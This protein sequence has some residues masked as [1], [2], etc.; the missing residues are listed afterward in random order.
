LPIS[1]LFGKKKVTSKG[2]LMKI[3]LFKILSAFFCLS[4]LSLYAD[5]VRDSSTGVAFPSEITIEHA[6]KQYL[7]QATGVAT[8]KKFFVKVYSVASYLQDA[9]QNNGDKFSAIMNMDKAKQ[10][11]L[12]FVHDAPADKVQ[13]GYQDSFHKVLS[14]AQYNQMQSQ[15]NTFVQFF[16][17]DMQKGGEQVIRWFPDGY[18][19]VLING[20]K[21][22]S[23][24]NSELAKAIWNIWFGSNS[25]VDRDQLVSLMH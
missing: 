10:L 12:K 15:I 3:S 18:V 11:T 23:L 17:Q 21:A 20:N 1:L 24:T 22:G 2:G 6:G 8:R 5:D 13:S 14:D 9:S 16:N 7:L 19:E 4:S 25:V